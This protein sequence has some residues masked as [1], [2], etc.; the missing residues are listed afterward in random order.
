LTST[1]AAI[2]QVFSWFT[3]NG[4]PN[5]PLNGAPTIPGVTPQIQ[6]SL[7]SPNSFEYAGGVNRQ[8]GGKAAVRVDGV[9]RKYRDFYSAVTNTGTGRAQDQ[10]GK[11]YDLTLVENDNSILKRQYA[12]MT[13]SAT[14][15]L[16]SLVD[17]GGNYTLSRTW[18]NFDGEN[19]G[20]GPINASAQQYPEYKQASWNYPDGDLSIDQRHRSRLWINVGVP[21]LQG[22]T[23]S[24]LQTLTSGVPYG[25]VNTSGINPI[26]YVANPGYL[27]PPPGSATTYYYTARDAFRTDGERRTDFAANYVYKIKGAHNVQLFGQLQVLNIFNQ[28]QL[29]GCGG[30]VF[31]NGGAVFSSRID[32]TVL[33]PVTN[34]GTYQAFNPFTTT[35]VQGVNWQYGPI[36][37]QALNRFAYTTPREIRISFGVRF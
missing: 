8:F 14:Y 1:P 27:T 19:V 16:S 15:R 24:G 17:F 23:L 34:P 11:S 37:G 32:Q 36:F 29:C 9:Y 33:T 5:L 35:P 6:G 22:L 31:T 10:F 25:A 7:D 21:W 13:T 3:A 20:S 30:T 28:F 26:P 4:G 18:G 2:Q 12:G